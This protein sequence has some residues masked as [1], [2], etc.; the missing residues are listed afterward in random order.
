MKKLE[1][2]SF[3]LL[4]LLLSVL[5][6]WLS[7]SY[8]FSL[9]YP[10]SNLPHGTPDW[11]FVVLNIALFSLFI[12]F[13]RFRRRVTRLPSSI[14]LAFIVALFTEMYGFPLTMYILTWLFGST[15]PGCLWYPLAVLT[16]EN[17]FTSIFL[18]FI[19]PISNII[20]LIGILL[21]I[22]GWR[23]IYR[24][25]GQLVTTGIYGH[26]RH[27]QYLG[28]LLLTL[29]MN[30][31]WVTISALLLWVILAIL[32]YRLAKE[33]DKELEERFGEEY[34]K[35]KCMVPMLIPRIHRTRS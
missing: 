21:I 10:L 30:M 12:V 15:F 19:L 6:V 33:E 26:I 28:F 22:F 2:I 4:A 32:Y 25:K 9:A 34:L 16:G 29:G 27:P 1:L 3:I 8:T 14:Y 11:D 5:L 35:Y 13:I 20:I 17:L 24:S 23:K 7:I 31:L 18:G